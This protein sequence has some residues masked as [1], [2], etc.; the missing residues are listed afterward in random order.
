MDIDLL[1]EYLQDA[2]AP[3]G[4]DALLPTSSHNTLTQADY[5]DWVA[6]NQEIRVRQY[7]NPNQAGAVISKI[8]D[9][10]EA[11]ADCI[12]A[13]GKELVIEL[14]SRSKSKIQLGEGELEENGGK[15]RR[16]TFPSRNLKEAWKFSKLQSTFGSIFLI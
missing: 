16:I 10:F 15:L 7:A 13:E 1:S 11:I 14:K 5:D 9:I 4:R 2:R 6:S 8:E 12:L 3:E